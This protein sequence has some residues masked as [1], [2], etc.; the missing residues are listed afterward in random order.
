MRR[1]TFAVRARYDL[2]EI[3]ERSSEAWGDS[4]AESY[5]ASIEQRVAQLCERPEA[6]PI[7]NSARP[8][9]RR[10]SIGSHIIFYRFDDRVLRVVRVLDQRMNLERHLRGFNEE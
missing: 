9:L 5:L 3:R 1:P 8:D 6:W 4:H 2:V 7:W 10:C